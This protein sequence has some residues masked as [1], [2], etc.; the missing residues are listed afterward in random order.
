MKRRFVRLRRVVSIVALVF[1]FGFFAERALDLVWSFPIERLV[2]DTSST[3][4]LARGG[5]ELRITAVDGER[6]LPMP[7]E[8]YSPWIVAAV[9]AAEDQRFREHSGVDWVA[10]LRA[11]ISNLTA[12]RVVSGASTL[13]MQLVRIAEPRPRRFTSKLIEAIRVR[14]LERRL[15]KDELLAA[16]LD[17]APLGS[18]ARGFEAAARLWFGISAKQV[19]ALQAATLVAMLPAPSKRA[20]DRNPVLLRAAR[21]RVLDR[22][23]K[24]GAIH[25]ITARELCERALEARRFDWPFFAPHFVDTTLR[26]ARPGEVGSQRGELRTTLDFD[27]Q[28]RVEAIVHASQAPGDGIAVVVLDRADGS[29]RASVGGRDWF[30][31]KIDAVNR[32]REVGSS[33]KPFLYAIAISCGAAGRDTLLPDSESEFAGFEPRNFDLNHKGTIRL[34]DALLE[35]RNVPAVALLERIGAERYR[36]GLSGLGLHLSAKRST[37]DSALGTVS[38]TPHQLAE[39]WRRFADPNREIARMDPRARGEVVS[40]LSEGHRLPGLVD[41]EG[42]A[43]KTGT[44]SGR[45]DAWTAGVTPHHAIAVWV[46][47][48][49]GTPDERFVGVR[50]AAPLFARIASAIEERDA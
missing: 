2:G 19:D 41:D 29:V 6:F 46:G 7:L 18:G 25:E 45:R 44:S 5:E 17:H 32:K 42:I 27:L 11:A 36:A 35:S 8:E 37:L 24:A 3:L 50:V 40:M 21:N 12:C 47:N 31:S 1:V 20:P 43:W 38:Y 30:E 4:V 34:K 15:S 14:Q 48:L 49:R 22:M 26:A 28:R 33:L 13:S 9:V 39:A 16:Y 10:V 23:A